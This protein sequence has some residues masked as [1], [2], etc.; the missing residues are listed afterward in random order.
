M[1]RS[2]VRYA[3]FWYIY[4]Y[5]QWVVVVVTVVGVPPARPEPE[6][7]CLPLY[8]VILSYSVKN[9]VSGQTARC[10]PAHSRTHVSF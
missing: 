2:D 4:S 8:F 6:T 5:Q 10:P 7:A 1:A 9:I 3:S